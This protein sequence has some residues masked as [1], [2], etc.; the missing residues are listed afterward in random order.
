MLPSRYWAF[1]AAIVL[2]LASAVAMRWVPGA[3]WGLVI[4]GALTLVGIGDLLQRKQALRR[5]FPLL[6]HFR[7]GLESIGPEIRQYFIEPDTE[8]TPFSRAQRAIVYQRAKDV[9]DK[10]PFGTQLNTYGD[11]YEWIN[12][13]LQPTTIV[14][15]DFR[16]RVGENRAQ[17]YDASVFNISAMS[18]G[19]LSANAIL[20]L[21]AGAK[22]GGFYH[23]TGEGSIS[24]YHRE[25]GGDLVWEV[26]SGY[27]GCRDEQGRFDPERFAKNAADPQVKMIEIKLSQGAKP[28]QGGILPAAKVSVEIAAARGITPGVECHS[29]AMHAE[30]STPIGLLEFVDR[31]RTLSGGKPTGF[32]LAIG[33][34]WEWFAI[35]KAMKETGLVPDFIVVDGGEGGTGAAPLEF[36]DHVGAPMREA[37]MLVHNTLVGLDLRSQVRLAAAGKIITAFDIARTL[38]LGA[39]WCNAARGFMFALG[40]IQSQS[41]HTDRCPT[42]VA[43]QDPH[44]QAALDPLDKA[45]RVHNFHR[46]TLLALKELLAAAG[47]THPAQLGPEHIIRRVSSTE[48]RSLATLHRFVRQGAL[49]DGM[50]D[51]AV[52]QVFWER[53]RADSFAPPPEAAAMLAS[54]LR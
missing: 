46:N 4:F 6:A 19:S 17:P 54:K 3:M 53:A 42:G 32:K 15:P 51:H 47:L 14:S 22:K 12:H 35:A 36:S 5:N 7:Y 48:V 1:A 9:L 45:T 18:F 26:A 44:R 27:F 52:F 13:S 11:D 33:H 38:A 28:G 8:E 25:H 34:P 37:L 24:R 29:P 31:L 41:C 20:A 16:I 50:P 10:R 49:L 23:D 39:D 2:T 43:T 21:N 30:F 40:C